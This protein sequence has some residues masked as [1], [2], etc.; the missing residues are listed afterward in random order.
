MLYKVNP[1]WYN[2]DALGLF[3]FQPVEQISFSQ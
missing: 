3:V 1:L 2:I